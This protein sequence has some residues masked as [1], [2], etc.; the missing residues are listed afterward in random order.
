MVHING[1]TKSQRVAAMFSRISRKYDFMNTVMTGG[2]HKRWRRLTAEMATRGLPP[3]PALDVGTG[4]GDLSFE[5][6]RRPEV[7]WV[8][9]VDFVAEMLALAQIKEQR[10]PAKRPIVWSLGD[11][12]TLPFPDS[13]F[14]CATAGFTMRNVADLHRAISEMARV[15]R[16][17]GRVVVLELT[18]PEERYHVSRLLAR[19]FSY[20]APLLGYLLAKD[21]EA[22]T[23]LPRSVE[24]FPTAGALALLMA[25][26]G[27]KNVDWQLLSMGLVA[28]HVGEVT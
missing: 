14:M 28:L 11:A 17:G 4:T 7:S 20:L 10:L 9:G 2:A 3:G 12:L 26:A 18:P 15:V 1:A 6:A 27:L 16:P 13:T 25:N 23:Y 22:Y 5:L 8:V 24:N 19:C 21:R